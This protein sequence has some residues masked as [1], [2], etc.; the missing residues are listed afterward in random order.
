MTLAGTNTYLYGSGP[1]AAID[2]GPDDAG[3]LD[4]IRAAAE[5]RGGIGLVLLTHSHGDHAAGAER[6]GA[7]VVLPAGGEE[8][9]GLRA[10]ATPGHAADHVC[11]LTADGVCFSGDLVLG[12]GS[13]F[14]PPDGGSLSSY[15]E[16]LRLLQS[17]TIELICPGHGPWIT[18]PAAKL[19]E[20]V[21]HREMRERRLL[22]ALER[23]E[24]SREVLLAEVWDDVP[25]EVRPAAAL[26]M[27][28][29]L[30]KLEAEGRLPGRL[31]N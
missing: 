19:T 7:E 29:H 2:P 13:T 31:A 20:Y 11:L 16:S 8:R 24:R 28:A 27:E 5:Q 10:L 21:E 12:E 4:A 14:V 25:D 3:H 1:C 18:D 30:Q 6:L 23:G 15:M 26:V 22:A 9:A 17:K